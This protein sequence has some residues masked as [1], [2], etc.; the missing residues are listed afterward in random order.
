M[1]IKIIMTN[2]LTLKHIS[3]TFGQKAILHDISFGLRSEQ[4]LT[5]LGP[6]GAGKST[7]I[8]VILGLIIPDT[9]TLIRQP[10]LRIGYV[11]QKIYLD[12]M[13][14]LTVE[15]FMRLRPGVT[16]KDIFSSLRD[17]KAEHLQDQLIQKLSGGEMQRV[18]LARALLH[19]PLLLVLDEP[20]QGIDIIGQMALYDLIYQLRRTLG[21]SIFMVSHDLN[22]VMAKT[23]KVMCLNHHI[24]CLG[25][26]E[27]VS[28]HP[29]FIAMFGQQY[30]D[31]EQ[32]LCNVSSL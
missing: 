28:T 10:S 22:L 32:F 12:P 21:C 16:K 15:R 19:N 2:L 11:P 30:H 6:N 18:M 29:D 24:C 4:T 1:T 20:T 9:G 3:V 8:Q 31:S 13:L 27:I 26:P 25:T 23:D 5:L 7:L 14:P 17:V